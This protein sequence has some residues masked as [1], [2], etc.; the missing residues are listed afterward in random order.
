MD[1][2]RGGQKMIEGEGTL[3]GFEN[4]IGWFGIYRGKTAEV[5]LYLL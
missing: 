3:T 2:L 5:A 1:C 4:A